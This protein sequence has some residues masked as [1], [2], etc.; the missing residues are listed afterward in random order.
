MSP[1]CSWS[2]HRASLQSAAVLTP[3]SRPGEDPGLPGCGRAPP[4]TLPMP[5]AEHLPFPFTV[6]TAPWANSSREPRVEQSWGVPCCDPCR[7]GLLMSEFLEHMR[8]A[9]WVRELLPL[10]VKEY[11][12]NRAPTFL[13]ECVLAVLLPAQ[14]CW[15][16]LTLSV[17]SCVHFESCVHF[18]SCVYF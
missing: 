2:R 12:Q 16:S 5:L 7:P 15:A 3:R 9:G 10:S 1:D 17:T 13:R 11:F 14:L 18:G 8:G 6:V 4:L